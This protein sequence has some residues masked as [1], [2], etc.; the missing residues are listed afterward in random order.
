MLKLLPIL[1]VQKILLYAD[2]TGSTSSFLKYV[3][4]NQSGEF[5][6][7]TEMYIYSSNEKLIVSKFY[8]CPFI[9]KAGCTLCNFV[10]KC[11]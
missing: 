6:V 9:D 3:N 4:E 2:F 1:N 10:L 8:D 7:L 11:S 5:I